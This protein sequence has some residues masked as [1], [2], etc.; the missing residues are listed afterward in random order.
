M[1]RRVCNRWKSCQ[2]L[3]HE[4]WKTSAWP[5]MTREWYKQ[6]TW[7]NLVHDII[8]YT[9]NLYTFF[10]Y[11]SLYVDVEHPSTHSPPTKSSLE[12]NVWIFSSSFCLFWLVKWSLFSNVFIHW[13][14]VNDIELHNGSLPNLPDWFQ[15]DLNQWPAR[16]VG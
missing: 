2:N 12:I 4:F 8:N 16:Q 1:G 3:C 14:T 15:N 11:H 5:N 10:R 13:Y 9:T 7:L 6:F